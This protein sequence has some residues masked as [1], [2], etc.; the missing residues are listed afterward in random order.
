M[1]K[2]ASEFAPLRPEGPLCPLL[3]DPELVG[4]AYRIDDPLEWERGRVRALKD[5]YRRSPEAVTNRLLSRLQQLLAVLHDPALRE[6]L[7]HWRRY[8]EGE[9]FRVGE[10]A[11]ALY[12]AVIEEVPEIDRAF[13]PLH[14]KKQLR[15]RPSGRNEEG[16][17]IRWDEVASFLA[18]HGPYIRTFERRHIAQYLGAFALLQ[19]DKA[20][21]ILSPLLDWDPEYLK[22]L[23]ATIE[24]APQEVSAAP[25]APPAVPPV[26]L[27]PSAPKDAPVQERPQDHR[28]ES[29]ATK[30]STGRFGRRLDGLE[31]AK[32]DLE[33]AHERLSPNQIDKQPA[34]Q[35]DEDL[36]RIHAYRQQREEV[37]RELARSISDLRERHNALHKSTG[38]TPCG[39]Q[40]PEAHDEV[41]SAA[42]IDSI[43][44]ELGQCEELLFKWKEQG[45]PAL[46]V[47]ESSE[48]HDLKDVAR[49]LSTSIAAE[50]ERRRVSQ[51]RGE[52][53]ISLLG[54]LRDAPLHETRE[55]AR[56]LGA[57]ELEA[58][59]WAVEN[60]PAL[61][62]ALLR[63]W[64]EKSPSDA[65]EY[66]R[67]SLASLGRLDEFELA[68]LEALRWLD[69]AHLEAVGHALGPDRER[70]CFALV[71]SLFEGRRP[72]LVHVLRKL[73]EAEPPAHRTIREFIVECE[74]CVQ[75]GMGFDVL[76]LLPTTTSQPTR[77]TRASDA[78]NELERHLEAKV[79]N[80][81]DHH[82]L[83]Q[84]AKSLYLDKARTALREGN[85]RILREICD[86]LADERAVHAIVQ[87]AG[88]TRRTL[89][90][91]H[92]TTLS[93]YLANHQRLIS[94]YL[95]AM[96]GGPTGATPRTQLLVAAKRVEER[97]GWLCS[98]FVNWLTRLADLGPRKLL[99]GDGTPQIMTDEGRAFC[100]SPRPPLPASFWCFRSMLRTSEIPLDDWLTDELLRISGRQLSS[101]HSAT[102]ALALQDWLTVKLLLDGSIGS[103]GQDLRR[104]FD[105]KVGQRARDIEAGLKQALAVLSDEERNSTE[106][107]EV[108][109]QIRACIDRV[110]LDDAAFYLD[111]VKQIVRDRS[112]AKR[113]RTEV[114]ALLALFSEEDRE[115]LQPEDESTLR[116]ELRRRRE[117]CAAQRVHLERLRQYT[118]R[119]VLSP[120]FRAK[121][122]KAIESADGPAYWPHSAQYAASL[123][124]CFREV[125]DLLDGLARVRSQL[126]P[127]AIE[128]LNR[129]LQA[130]EQWIGTAL[131]RL[132]TE[133]PVPPEHHLLEDLYYAC[134]LED[135][136]TAIFE[137]LVKN[138]LCEGLPE[139]VS[140]PVSQPDA[141][142]KTTLPP[143]VS[144]PVET[145]FLTLTYREAHQNVHELMERAGSGPG[146]DQVLTCALK[147]RDW[148]EIWRQAARLR[149]SLGGSDG[150]E[151]DYARELEALVSIA[152][153]ADKLV[154]ARTEPTTWKACLHAVA[155][156][157]TVRERLEHDVPEGWLTLW[158]NDAFDALMEASQ[159]LLPDSPAAGADKADARARLL[160]D[161]SSMPVQAPLV[162]WFRD[163]LFCAPRL[164]IS[165]LWEWATSASRAAEARA[166]LLSFLYERR[167][168][169]GL[170]VALDHFE[171]ADWI[172]PAL[173]AV[174]Q[175]RE[176]DPSVEVTLAT[177]AGKLDDKTQ[178][179]WKPLRIFVTQCLKVRREES[180]IRQVLLS[181]LERGADGQ[182]VGALR[183]VPNP[184]NPPMAAWLK[185]G[186][187]CGLRLVTIGD[188]P[189]E[190]RLPSVPLLSDAEEDISF[191]AEGSVKAGGV[192]TIPYQLTVEILGG[193][194][195]TIEGSWNVLMGAADS[196]EPATESTV[197]TCYAGLGGDVVLG[198]SGGFFGRER[199]L[200]QIERLVSDAVRPRSSL[201][202][203]MRRIGKT[204]LL[205]N[206]LMQ[207]CRANGADICIFAD[208]GKWGW[209]R[210]ERMFTRSFFDKVASE[211]FRQREYNKHL[212]ERL[213]G[214]RAV[215]ELAKEMPATEDAA[216][217]L[218]EYAERISQRTQ[219]RIQRVY[220]FID[221]FDKLMEPYTQW[222]PDRVKVLCGQLRHVAQNS[223]RV[224]LLLACSPIA[225]PLFDDAAQPFYG[226]I[227]RL[228][229]PAFDYANRKKACR[230]ILA[231]L[232]MDDRL[233]IDDDVAAYAVKVCGGVPYFMTMLG[234]A[235][236]THARR[237]RVTRAAVNYAVERLVRGDVP[238]QH[239]I[240]RSKFLQSLQA[241]E[242]LPPREKKLAELLLL[243]LSRK[244]RLDF[245]EFSFPELR[246][247]AVLRQFGQ[248]A[249]AVA[250]DR[251]IDARILERTPESQLRFA[252]PIVCE[253][254]RIK[255]EGDIA[256]LV[257]ELRRA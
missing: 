219:G 61:T 252:S 232:Q 190:I 160:R 26:E 66:V 180:A 152:A 92:E 41:A 201:V 159:S 135:A 130:L 157:E 225:R 218:E 80:S 113:R 153:A 57:P 183:L 124:M 74:R 185:L 176:S 142:T 111:Y 16:I 99:L 227:P 256:R 139:P 98:T 150:D 207:R 56:N 250:R 220:F 32:E 7:G 68:V 20:Y 40:I 163:A 72:E 73:A 203:G 169:D 14:F 211:A 137:V 81:G 3:T 175:R 162:S 174:L 217:L 241:L 100:I 206:A 6:Q 222:T 127:L 71:R 200:E 229:V 13:Q 244:V 144:P 230:R 19:S 155:L 194:R 11:G 108:E 148:N 65:V 43:A 87:E 235:I 97:Q 25:A 58:L 128:R 132:A 243:V 122:S 23:S 21:A 145:G 96:A 188:G 82:T 123:E 48:P 75:R 195:K 164:L 165:H 138:K 17:F 18:K 67:S 110:E 237:R 29:V 50:A 63:R 39:L 117:A 4:R 30:P 208:L 133:H 131:I 76:D 10:C 214:V 177:I 191:A 196:Y 240:D 53:A 223:R 233:Y 199:E 8:G 234:A 101:L 33:A 161:L 9:W 125:M 158:L 172:T 119:N 134:A 239:D 47:T 184:R 255:A 209:L 22:L 193:E 187:G 54:A 224:G 52:R 129:S 38:I 178:Q 103:E 253:V 120:S 31:K 226:S 85:L 147:G 245:P 83:R 254:L 181:E 15:C 114:V 247:D 35:V 257:E 42:A 70:F 228:E 115:R 90:R 1:P 46:V 197:Q 95:S 221:E 2:Y 78:R 146:D 215:E 109:G 171:G 55:Y 59:C 238:G 167:L 51:L 88:L 136:P 236:A 140:Q 242:V 168:W 205:L 28:Q 12:R 5:V 179:G 45:A 173:Y 231:P 49:I 105:E 198:E 151:T 91:Q 44:N 34:S 249:C 166:A 212:A 121:L 192:I 37:V 210:D 248:E 251:L 77:S 107:G 62:G 246:E 118:Q 112:E 170:R 204:S 149:R 126:S 84:A 186:A 104:V 216:D 182:W 94:D 154:S 106:L 102:A 189:Y 60:S 156:A 64:I 141:P 24:A 213:G 27:A 86:A 69:L 89:E 93:R 36:K 202:I 79:M 116:A 143:Q